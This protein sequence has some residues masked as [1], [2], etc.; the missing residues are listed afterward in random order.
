MCLYKYMFPNH[1]VGGISL[2]SVWVHYAWCL[3][4][5]ARAVDPTRDFTGQ[6]P[7]QPVLSAITPTGAGRAASGQPP[8]VH[9]DMPNA[10]KFG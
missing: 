7:G 6:S 2:G 1:L 5:R 8:V 9:S 10:P 3:G 4:G